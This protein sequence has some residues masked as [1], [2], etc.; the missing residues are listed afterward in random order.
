MHGCNRIC[1]FC[2]PKHHIDETV[3]EPCHRLSM[4]YG[5]PGYTLVGDSPGIEPLHVFILLV[6][7]SHAPA[8]GDEVNVK[9]DDNGI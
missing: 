5:T 9:A 8:D 6:A 3:Q 1:I 4:L 2:V 7:A